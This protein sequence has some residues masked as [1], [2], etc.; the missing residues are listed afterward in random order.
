MEEAKRKMELANNELQF[1]KYTQEQQ[2]RSSGFFSK[3]VLKKQDSKGELRGDSIG[4]PIN[5]T[6]EAHIGYDAEGG[7]FQVNFTEISTSTYFLSKIQYFQKIN[8]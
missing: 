1:K 5:V 4:V 6:H 2:K 7:G 3:F 8:S